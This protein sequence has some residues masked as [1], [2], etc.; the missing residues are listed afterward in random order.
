MS[1][2]KAMPNLR[3]MSI[4]RRFMIF[5]VVELALMLMVQGVYYL[6]I[7]RD[8]RAI[9]D[10]YASGIVQQAVNSIDRLMDIS[11]QVAVQVSYGS[12][13]QDFLA[14]QS[15]YHLYQTWM[16][17]S[18]TIRA[19]VDTNP[20][21]YDLAIYRTDQHIRYQCNH[22]NLAARA[23]LDRYEQE[24]LSQDVRAGFVCLRDEGNKL[25]IPAYIQPIRF[26]GNT[27]RWRELIGTEVVMLNPELLNHIM[28]AI[29]PVRHSKFYLIDTEGAVVSSTTGD[30]E[31]VHALLRR[32][33][34]I[35]KPVGATGW[36]LVCLLGSDY[37]MQSYSSFTGFAVLVAFIMVVLALIIL[38]TINH[39]IVS[40]L[41]RLHAEI[42]D[43]MASGFSK[44]VRVPYRNEM[45]NMAKAI[46]T[47]LDRQAEMTTDILLVQQNLYETQLD[48][49]QNELLALQNQVN[50]H[51]L[52]NTMQCICGMAMAAGAPMIADV[53]TNMTDIFSYSLRGKDIVSLHDE[54]H[55]LKQY[56]A[57]IDS[58]FGSTF[59]WDIRVPDD[60]LD[61][62]I[63]KM[64]LQPLAENAIYHGLERQGHG[65][66]R[67][68][69]EESD[70]FVQISL[71]DDGAGIS[72]KKLRQLQQML[73]NRDQM[74]QQSRE[75][76]RIGIANTC[77]RLQIVFGPLSGIEI[78]NAPH[79]GT[80]C[81]VRIP[82]LR[83]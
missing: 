43:V 27:T 17:Q 69:A 41:A 80:L 11:R 70:G 29:P 49:K 7:S 5:C 56:L 21:I 79:R 64:T 71:E 42:R 15:E 14:P 6:R 35:V 39:S 18:D 52:L 8:T 81:V 50:P 72:P 1:E 10:D 2:D 32:P 82:R 60:L 67:V 76:K 37:I 4:R 48:A 20:N 44:R 12:L 40:P 30:N 13:I 34:V 38:R 74:H 23:L 51:F 63:V 47:M 19:M 16:Y 66:L 45:G 65:T 77:W 22:T 57:I 61:Q 55:C 62:R 9:V 31:D 54:L 24:L 58:R 68:L 25:L 59:H 26:T 36:Q 28:E 33:D 83:A 78:Q 73:E 53:T 75:H 46:N 3:P